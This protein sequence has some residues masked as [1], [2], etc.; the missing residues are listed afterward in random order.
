[1]R[2]WG[3]G[4]EE[5]G[6]R[7][8]TVQSASAEAGT[9]GGE[10]D[11][12]PWV[13][14]LWASAGEV[15]CRVWFGAVVVRGGSLFSVRQSSPLP[16][17]QSSVMHGSS[18]LLLG[19]VSVEKQKRQKVTDFSVPFRITCVTPCILNLQLY[20]RLALGKLLK[21]AYIRVKKSWRV[22]FEVWF[23]PH[24]LLS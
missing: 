15:W 16:G 21:A 7:W 3:E 11:S 12:A 14:Q 10:M 18:R 6:G 22:V 8:S 1:M 24:K 4:G 9:F 13:L 17:E 5:E 23:R 19:F 20:R 2:F